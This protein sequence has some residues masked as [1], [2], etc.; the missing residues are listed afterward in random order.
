MDLEKAT[1]VELRQLVKEKGIKNASKLK[2]DEL[3]KILKDE[4]NEKAENET[5]EKTTNVSKRFYPLVNEEITPEG[6][7]LEAGEGYKLTS[8]DDRIVQGV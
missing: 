8:E 5:A 2:K 6:P 4:K 7:A 3:I 1:L